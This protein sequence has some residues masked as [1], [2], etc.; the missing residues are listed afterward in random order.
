MSDE[1]SHL[2]T[3]S[4]GKPGC[5]DASLKLRRITRRLSRHVEGAPSNDPNNKPNGAISF[6]QYK[7]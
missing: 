5:P 3:T 1:R 7:K 4:S 6:E 2:G